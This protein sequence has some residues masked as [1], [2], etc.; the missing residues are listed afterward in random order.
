MAPTPQIVPHHE[1]PSEGAAV[2]A[3]MER[4]EIRERRPAFRRAIA[5]DAHGLLIVIPGAAQHEAR[6]TPDL[7]RG[8]PG[9]VVR[10]RPARTRG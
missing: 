8:E 5:F 10:C 4:S 6:P 7:I 1:D 9:E 2:V 3:R